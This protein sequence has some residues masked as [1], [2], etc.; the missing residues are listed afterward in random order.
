MN[1][2]EFNKLGLMDQID[3][4]NI[5]LE[6][7]SLTKI[8]E[9]IKV[10]RKT[11]RNRFDKFGYVYDKQSNKYIIKANSKDEKDLNN[12]NN[13]N[14]LFDKIES[15]EGRIKGLEDRLNNS[16]TE[17][18]ELKE[19]SIKSLEGET[20]SRCYRLNKEVQKEFSD[21]CKRNSSY[22]VQDIL[23]SALVEFIEKYK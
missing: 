18:I 15:L 2:E 16:K 10:S 8:S 3:F 7:K 13:T 9:E 20:V 19:I 17:L 1:K 5:E 12:A 11:L 23:G 22:K 14:V 6:K 4:V 21:F